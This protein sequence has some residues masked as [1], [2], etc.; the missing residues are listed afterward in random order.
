MDDR[1]IAVIEMDV[2]PSSGMAE[3]LRM[4]GAASGF[5]EMFDNTETYTGRLKLDLTAGKVKKCLEKLRSEWIIIDPSAGQKGDKEPTVL[6]M[7]VA[8]LYMLEKID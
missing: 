6:K 7:G 8:R 5:S 3:Q 4:E 2:I 1:Q